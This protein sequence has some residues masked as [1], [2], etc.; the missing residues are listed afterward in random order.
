MHR[1]I[2]AASWNNTNAITKG[3]YSP[4]V[5]E[6][7]EAIVLQRLFAAYDRETRAHVQRTARWARAVACRLHFADEEIDRVY[8]A[9]LL[10]DIGKIS[11]SPAILHKR[12]ALDEVEQ[13]IIRLHPEI[14]YHIL[15]QAGGAF[16]ALATIVVAHHE[17]WDGQGYPLG[18][19]G[20]EIPL[21]A[22]ILAVV[23]AFDAMTSQRCYRRTLPFS[24]ACQELRNCAGSRYDTLI[25]TA[26]LAVI[27][28]R[29]VHK[30]PFLSLSALL[31]P[32]ALLPSTRIDR[33][34]A[35]LA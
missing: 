7:A 24:E 19:A 3:L 5:A 32:H 28:E 34:A 27:E 8:L 2:E 17:R 26:F 9:A 1:N 15:L 16:G 22:R 12:G 29:I 11:I 4:P 35:A 13:R 14:G 21:A 20:E 6:N 31:L 23:D 18:L 25:V 10:H 30:V 33:D